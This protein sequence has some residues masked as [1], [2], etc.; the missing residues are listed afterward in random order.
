MLNHI[1]EEEVKLRTASLNEALRIKEEFLQNIN[2]EIRTP[3]QVISGISSL[4]LD[5]YNKLSDLKKQEMLVQLNK[6]SQRLFKLVTNVLDLLRFKQG[7]MILEKKHWQMTEIVKNAV[8]EMQ[9]L[10]DQKHIL[11][12]VQNNAS[13]EAEVYIDKDKIIQVIINLLSNSIKYS[14]ERTKIVISVSEKKQLDHN[15]ILSDFL[16]VS[17]S[18]N[19]VGIPEKELVSIFQSFTQSTRTNNKAGGSGLGLAIV[20]EIIC[21]HN[22]VINVKNNKKGGCTFYFSIPYLRTKALKLVKKDKKKVLF[23]DDEQ[24]CCVVGSMILESEGFN[25]HSVNSGSAAMEYLERNYQDIDIVFLDVM[26]PGMNGLQCLENI[27]DNDNYKSIPIIM[28]TGIGN[29]I[30]LKKAVSLGAKDCIAKPYVK[31]RLV[32]VMS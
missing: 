16:V 29:E 6:S 7:K 11:I 17:V 1:L 15:G 25:V 22:G 9:F 10:A 20:A 21:S 4:L 27:Q 19:G 28:Q 30:E 5:N 23:V 13:K 2:H 31:E 32:E 14:Q 18:D 26:M 3:V 8:D 24:G 12:E